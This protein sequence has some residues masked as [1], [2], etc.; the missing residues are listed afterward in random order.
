M[1][2][3]LKA[4]QVQLAKDGRSDQKTR[5]DHAHHLR[6]PQLAGQHAQQ[7]GRQQDHGDVHQDIHDVKFH[8]YVRL[9]PFFS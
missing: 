5:Q 8:G 6:Q 9:S 3:A 2:E 4:A 7:L 1:D